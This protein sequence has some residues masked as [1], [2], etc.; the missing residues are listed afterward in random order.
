MANICAKR[1]VSK[2]WKKL[3]CYE[4]C[5]HV[6]N[7]AEPT[8][9]FT[10]DDSFGPLVRYV[11]CQAC[12]DASDEAAYE[13][14][15][16]CGKSFNPT[17]EGTMW[18]YYDFY[19]PQGDEE[20][21]ICGECIKGQKHANRLENDRLAYNQE[22]GIPEDFIITVI[23]CTSVQIK[24][25][26]SEILEMGEPENWAPNFR[27]WVTL[28]SGVSHMLRTHNDDLYDEWCRYQ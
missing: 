26:A 13:Y 10:E 20:I 12:E 14:C 28:K 18:R 21:P 16:D 4:A 22:M 23:S 25:W 11:A 3:P 1:A 17:K 8:V 7:G 6:E 27:S 5:E 24:F 15:R 19:A 9:L 2:D